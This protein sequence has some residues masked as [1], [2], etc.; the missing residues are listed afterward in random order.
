MLLTTSDLSKIQTIDH[1]TNRHLADYQRQI[2]I[3]E[4]R[5]F[6]KSLDD[7]HEVA[8]KLASFGQSITL[9]VSQ[10]GY[11]NPDVLIFYGYVGDESATLLQHITQ[12]SF[13]LTS[14]KKRIPDEPP[15]RIGFKLPAQDQASQQSDSN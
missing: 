8:L 7:E 5:E 15:C 1:R 6:E 11:E 12:L 3:E 2:I 13:L 4:I 14:A 10:I 9:S